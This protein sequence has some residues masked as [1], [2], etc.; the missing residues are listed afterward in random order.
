MELKGYT[1]GDVARGLLDRLLSETREIV[2]RRGWVFQLEEFLPRIGLEGINERNGN[3]VVIKVRLRRH[4]NNLYFLEWNHI[5]GTFI[6]ELCHMEVYDHGPNFKALEDTLYNE[7]DNQNSFKSGG[8]APKANIPFNTSCGRKLGGPKTGKS[9][10]LNIGKKLGG[11]P[12][13]LHLPPNIMSASA[14][15]AKYN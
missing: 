3:L 15:L 8:Y 10:L 6:H 9:K 11:T 1:N 5:L 2:R 7:Y 12:N 14:F 4:D 13:N